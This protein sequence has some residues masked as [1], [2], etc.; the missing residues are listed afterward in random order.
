MKNLIKSF[1]LTL[2]FCAFFAICYVLVLWI[3]AQVA[4]PNS[5]DA[6]VLTVDGKVVGSTISASNS[7]KIYISG[8]APP[9]P[10]TDTMLRAPQ[11]AI[12]DRQT[13]LT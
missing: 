12:K 6:E 9:M 1:R 11:E 5:G 8:D 7:R 4:G 13:K 2:V 3:F 10:V